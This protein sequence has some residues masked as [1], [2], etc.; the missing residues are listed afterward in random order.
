MKTVDDIWNV[1]VRN[2]EAN[3]VD[4]YLKARTV[5]SDHEHAIADVNKRLQDQYIKMS[6]EQSLPQAKQNI[7][8]QHEILDAINNLHKELETT[9]KG[10]NAYLQQYTPKQ[11]KEI[12]DAGDAGPNGSLSEL[13]RKYV[14]LIDEN[15]KT[16]LDYPVKMGVLEPIEVD[17]IG[18]KH[19]GTH[20]PLMED[21]HKGRTG[22]A[23]LFSNAARS[24]D[25]LNDPISTYANSINPFSKLS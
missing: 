3:D 1:L 9:I 16:M 18:S 24:V 14:Q 11:L 6:A 2:G 23:R 12:V 22:V 15:Q 19:S 4:P 7:P 25:N 5:L 17:K 21:R 20:V 8:K 13:G 10:E